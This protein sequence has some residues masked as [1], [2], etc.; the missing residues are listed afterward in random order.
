M[1]VI[2]RF[3][4]FVIFSLLCGKRGGEENR[5]RLQ[6]KQVASLGYCWFRIKIFLDQWVFICLTRAKIQAYRAYLLRYDIEFHINQL[7]F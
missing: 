1:F 6:K 3:F 7:P 4:R 5:S 2:F